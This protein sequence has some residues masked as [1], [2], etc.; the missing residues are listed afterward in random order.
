MFLYLLRAPTYP[1]LLI[2]GGQGFA[3][4]SGQELSALLARLCPPGTAKPELILDS[5][6]WLFTYLPDHHA[7]A[8]SLTQQ[9]APSKLQLIERINARA[10]R[11][12]G[13]VVYPTTSLGSRTRERVFRDLVEILCSG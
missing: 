5:R 10:N 7:L 13:S 9:H 6:W 1:V 2:V 8:P 11:A 12:T 3:A 4:T